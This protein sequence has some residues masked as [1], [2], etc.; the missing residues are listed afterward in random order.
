MIAGGF[1]MNR[2]KMPK[3]PFCQSCGLPLETPR[4]FGT[5]ASGSRINDFCVYCYHNGKFVEPD[6]SVEEM[7][8]RVADHLVK[9]E[10]MAPF[11]ARDVAEHFVPRLKRWERRRAS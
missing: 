11:Q 3:G 6:V 7:I 4:E 2:P 1:V 5:D 8:E 10:H 9:Q